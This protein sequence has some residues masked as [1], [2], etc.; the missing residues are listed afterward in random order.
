MKFGKRHYRPQVD[1]MD[2]GVAS[3]AMVF[4][5]YGSYYFLAHLRELAKTTMDGT[6]ALGLVKVAEEIGF[7]TRAIKADMTLFDLPDLTFPFVAHVLKEGKL[8]HYYVVTGQDKDSIHI[9]D[10]DPGV[11]LTKLPRERFA[12][13]W[14]GVTLFMAPSPDYK[15]HKEQKNGLFSFIPILVKQRGLIANIVL[16]TLLVTVINIVGSYYLQSII[17]TYVPD[18]MRSTLGI[19]SIGLVIVYIL[20]Q[21]LSYAQEYLLLVLGQRLSIDV[22]LSYIKH[23]F[24]LP[25][26]FFATRRTGEIV[27]RFTDANSIIDALASTILSIFLDV[28]TVV[29]ISLVLFS[30]NTNL[31]FMTLLALPIYTVIIFA[32]MKP[33]EKMNRDTME[34]N[35]VLSSSIIEDINGI[36]TIKSLT[37]ESQ[38]YQKIDK[39][40][41]DYLK[42]SFTYSRAESQQKALKKVAH[43]LLN[44]GILWMGAVLVM[45]GKMSLGQLITY[46]T[47]LVYFTNPLENIINLQT[48]LQTAQVANNRLNEVYLVA[49]E[50]EEKKTV[51]DLSLMKG[52]MTFKQVHYKYGY[53]RD[54]LS[55]INLT[56]PQG[57]K[58]AFVGI[59]GSGKTTLA[60]M[61]VNFYDPSQGEISLGSVNLNQID[62]KALR[63]YINYLPQQPYVFNGTILEP[64]LFTPNL[65]TIQNPCLS[66]DPGWF[67][68]SPNGCFL[69]DKKEFPLYGISVEKNTKRK[70]THM[71][72]L[73]NHHFQNKSFYQLSFDGGHLTQYGGLIFF[74]E[75]FSQL[76]LKER[77]SK[78]LVT[79]DQ[80]RYCRY[81]DSDILVQFLFQLLTGYGTDY[82]CKELS[83]DAYFPKLLEGGQLAS[84]PT[85]SR[86]L[87]RTD[88]ETVHSLR[89][90]NLE[91]V[92]FFLQFHQLNQ[93]IVDIDSTHFTTY[94]KQEGVAYNA[95]YRAHGYHPLYAFEGKTGYCFNAQLRPGNR[96]CS[97]EADSFIT[98]VLERF[99]QLLFRMDSGFATPKLYDLIEKTGQYYL[100]KLK[101]NTV[102]SR[103]GDLSLPCPQDE[104][105]TI[106][107]HSAYSETL[108]QAGSWSHKRRVCQ[109]S[110]RKEGNLFYD[111][112]SLVTNMTSGTS[113]DQ[114]QLYRGRGQA[115]NFIKEMKEGFFGD[116]TD[117]STLIKNE[118]RMMM[119]CIAYNL[120]LFLKHLAGGDFQT[121]TIKRFRHLFL[122]VVGK[123]VRTGRKQLLKLSSLYAYSELFSALY[124]R[125]RKV[126]L[127]LPVPYEPP[128]RKASLMM[129]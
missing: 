112:I 78:Y 126:N 26:S 70:E 10:P 41:V 72:S 19:I 113:Q 15:P 48:K 66:L 118:V 21:I 59:S 76:K 83:A 3:L 30:Q 47:L 23:V 4:G 63:Q 64:Q 1:Q 96:Y 80:R 55:D 56:V 54:V 62:K 44:V 68:F 87:S 16:A 102:L 82:A 73:P 22:I 95:H 75:L 110:E 120:Y 106:L 49:S 2:C 42:K 7:E 45:D 89:C 74:Q 86:F 27:S 100:I 17:D 109:F 52:D 125:I 114:F 39:E 37:S 58:V 111:V 128:R 116:K 92:E 28:S 107:P 40:F 12:E 50:F 53:G 91:L 117:S 124:S 36:E 123:C 121:L 25:M 43:L 6:T 94:G 85:L 5:Y 35:A 93:L 97:E 104:D 108:Y 105:L 115:E 32:F 81:S 18:Q 90:L 119:S 88:E 65:K 24:H 38:R 14:T 71:N 8:L 29:I 122:H 51:E 127:N 13:E 79:N 31:F 46:N 11:K 34:A 101:K 67:L 84:Q 98:P 33:F 60:K 103:L 9:A 57:S 129:H 99:N 20:Q 61:M 69:L 77:I